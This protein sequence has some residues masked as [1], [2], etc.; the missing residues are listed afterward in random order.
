MAIFSALLL[1]VSMAGC[2]PSNAARTF[3]HEAFTFTIPAGWQTMEE[4]WKRPMPAGQA[5]YDLGV[6]EIVMIQYPAEPGK[7]V[8]FFA[9]ASAPLAEGQDLEKRFTETYQAL[10]P[11]IRQATTRSFARGEL[12]GYEITY[13]RP[14]GEPWWQFRDIWLEKDGMVYV[15]SCHAQPD[16]FATYA[17]V[18]EQ[19]IDSFRFR[20]AD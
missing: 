9:V 10:A 4:V 14:W 17:G 1:I 3:E 15:L 8:A 18:C 11:A 20:G 12:S 5:Y 19:I 6:Q 2:L 16:A 13:T 7:G